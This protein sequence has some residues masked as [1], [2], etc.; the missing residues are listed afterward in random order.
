MMAESARWSHSENSY[1]QSYAQ[2]KKH[3]VRKY[4][5]LVPKGRLELPTYALRMRRSKSKF[6]NPNNILVLAVGAQK[7]I[8]RARSVLIS[9]RRYVFVRQIC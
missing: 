2:T 4:S 5:I 1:K 6:L 7:T 3:K 9:H 8:I